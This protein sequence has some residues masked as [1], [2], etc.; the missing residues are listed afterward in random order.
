MGGSPLDVVGEEVT[1]S[2]IPPGDVHRLAGIG[3]Q[4]RVGPVSGLL[5]S[6]LRD[7]QQHPD[8]PHRKLGTEIG[9]EVDALGTGKRIEGPSTELAQL[10]LERVHLLGREHP[11][12]QAAVDGVLGRILEDHHAGRHLD[13]GL[14]EL[15]HRAP[16]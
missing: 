13:V 8:G 12:E 14:D 16:R 2:H 10:W 11:G 4:R 15:E 1:L 7:A 6:G 3:A 5:L 9:H